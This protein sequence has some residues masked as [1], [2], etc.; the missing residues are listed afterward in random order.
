MVDFM[1]LDPSFIC[2]NGSDLTIKLRS[3]A[4]VEAKKTGID[5]ADAAIDVK[6]NDF[7]FGSGGA[8]DISSIRIRNVRPQ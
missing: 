8:L 4:I 2:S 5:S 6:G 7:A 1:S 3:G